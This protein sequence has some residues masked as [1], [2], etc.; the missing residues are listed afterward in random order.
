V[1]HVIFT[2]PENH[3]RLARGL[4]GY[5]RRFH[6][7]IRLVAPAKAAA[8]QRGMDDHFFWRQLGSLRD[9]ALRPLRRLRWNPRFRAVRADLHGAIHRL[10]AGVRG[11]GKL[12]D[13]FD[14]FRTGPESG[15]RI[16]VVADDFSGLGGIR[17][18]LFM[19]L[20]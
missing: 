10:H 8:H 14:F 13:R 9:D 5:L 1:L 15:V 16:A 20:G 6:D 19:K 12:V 11:E 3:D 7:E 2:G 17:E 4:C 18:K